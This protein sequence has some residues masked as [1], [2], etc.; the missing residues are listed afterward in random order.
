MAM[1]G[2][3]QA[4]FDIMIDNDLLV[5]EDQECLMTS[6]TAEDLENLEVGNSSSVCCIVDDDSKSECDVFIVVFI[7]SSLFVT[8]VTIGFLPDDYS[9]NEADGTV[10][11]TVR[12]LAGQLARPV[13]VDFTTRDGTATSTAP[14]D[15]VNSAVLITLQFTPDDLER[16]VVVTIIND[17]IPENAEFFNGLLSTID[18]AVILD[19][20]TANVEI[21]D[22][23]DNEQVFLSIRL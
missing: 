9:V 20:D 16:E 14:E 22:D 8:D 5:E 23:D 3:S 11:L 1:P 4:C 17:N 21:I 19:P 6:F 2:T 12:V 10:T 18:L 7:I 13:E 15:F